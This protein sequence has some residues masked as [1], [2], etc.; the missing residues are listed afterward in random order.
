MAST[1]S[2][3]RPQ[4]VRI[5]W[6][7]RRPPKNLR[8]KW[9][10]SQEH[11]IIPATRSTFRKSKQPHRKNREHV[12]ADACSRFSPSAKNT[13]GFCEHEI[14]NSQ[15]PVGACSAGMLRS[16][17]VNADRNVGA[18]VLPIGH[19]GVRPNL[20]LPIH[21]RVLVDLEAH[22]LRATCIGRHMVPL[23]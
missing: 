23:I 14:P 3:A 22:R 13:T 4:S 2:R 5:I 9:W 19:I 16:A 1:S 8:E 10:S 7:T 6:T 17:Y 18:V 11:W 15:N 12:C 21:C 20:K